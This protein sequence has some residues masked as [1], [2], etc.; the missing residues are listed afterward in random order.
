MS[1]TIRL[2]TA[3]AIVKFLDQQ[4]VSMDGEETKFVEAFFTLFGH[5]IA[6]GLGEALDTNPGGIKVMQGR[7]EQGMC[8]CA[9]AYAKQN[10]RKKIIPCASSIGPGAANMVTACGT[11]TVNNIPLLVFPSDTYASRQPDPVLQQIEQPSS[12]ATTTNDAF[13]PVVKYWDRIQRP[14]Q[15]MSALINAMRVL[16]DPA[17]AGAVAIALPQDV[18]GE[19]FDYPE[20]FFAKRVHRITRPVAVAEELADV[21]EVIK[22]SKK[23]IVIVGGGARFSGAGEAIEQFCE[24]FNIPFGETQG[25]KSACISSNPYCLGG[26]GVTGTS[27]SNSIAKEADCVI[28]IGT[29]MTD[30]TTS[31]KWLFH[32]EDVKFA[33]INMS[34]F[35]A[36][37]FDAVKAVGDA[38]ETVKALT[39]ILKEAGYRSAYTDE[40]EKA[41]KDWDEELARLGALV[42]DGPDFEPTIK[43]R[44]PRTIPEFFKMYGT[45]LTQSAAL[46]VL[47]AFMAPN[48]T[49]VCAGGSLPSDLQRVWKTDKRGGYHVEYG[50]S[51]MGYEIGASMG[52]KMAQPEDEEYTVVGDAGFQMLS[53]ELGTIMQERIKTNIL[54]FDNCGFG[55]INNLE[56]T[57]GIGS[58]ATEFRYTDGKKP[59]GDLIRT[60][61]AK[62]GE[63]FGMKSYTCKSAEELKAALEDSKKQTVACLFDLK[64][65]P[66]TMTDGYGSWWNVGI[67]MTSESESVR[68]A[69]REVLEHREQA[70]KY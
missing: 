42:C 39:A 27:A 16:T 64:V 60:D 14:E 63:A 46:A 1:K 25:G 10:D 62:I 19:F 54:V 47:R 20:S 32:N 26:I 43:A 35:H 24:E 65:L 28:G 23:P 51:C 15:L 38:R 40:I 69:A 59:T 67:A 7:N 56:M 2:T 52:V 44:D 18:E 57:H 49:I 61:Y 3:Q 36:Y 50:Y 70:R 45:S 33:S 34:R 9:I 5:G 68:E 31:S 8:H 21:A 66:K 22:A 17:E 41:R 6:V 29:R 55:C 53:S 4:Y 48:D 58:I 37:K 30:F 12:L 13:K 11:A